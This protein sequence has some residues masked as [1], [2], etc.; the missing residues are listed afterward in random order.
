MV[1]VRTDPLPDG[2]ERRY[3]SNPYLRQLREGIDGKDL[4]KLRMITDAIQRQVHKLS[5]VQIAP[6]TDHDLQRLID[7]GEG[8]ILVGTGTLGERIKI[9]NGQLYMS[10]SRP[11][12]DN[13][14]Y[15]FELSDDQELRVSF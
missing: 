14:R 8:E 12:Y 1:E 15:V 5:K 7:T 6:M 2:G 3:N 4:S 13:F 10:Y 9:K 11:F